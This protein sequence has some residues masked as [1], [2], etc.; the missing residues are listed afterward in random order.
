[1]GLRH[2]L[3]GGRAPPGR[4]VPVFQESP[5]PFAE[6]V[7]R[8][9]ALAEAVLHGQGAFE[10]ETRPPLKGPVHDFE[11][12]GRAL[13]EEGGGLVVRV[14]EWFGQRRTARLALP[15]LKREWTAAM[16]PHQVKTFLVPYDRRARVR[17][18]NLL[19]D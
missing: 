3:Q 6:V 11:A 17:E 12:R 8:H 9:E 7:A 5:H 19:E 16:G 4:A 13:T 15:A 1:M 14:V 18:V 10:V 2:I